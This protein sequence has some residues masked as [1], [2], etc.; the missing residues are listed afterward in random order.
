[1]E[2]RPIT[3]HHITTKG[4][5]NAGSPKS[6]GLSLSL[7][8]SH[9]SPWCALVIPKK[10]HFDSTKSSTKG[11]ASEFQRNEEV[12]VGQDNGEKKDE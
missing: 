11:A 12:V 6:K 7:S 9:T 5:G 4:K 1:M 2:L 10:Q 8:L 3:S